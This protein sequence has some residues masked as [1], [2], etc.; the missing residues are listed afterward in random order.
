[1]KISPREMK[2]KQTERFTG[3][4]KISLYIKGQFAK[5]SISTKTSNLTVSNL[6]IYK[7]CRSGNVFNWGG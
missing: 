5:L 7:T 2:T 3:M 4:T 1:M 6:S